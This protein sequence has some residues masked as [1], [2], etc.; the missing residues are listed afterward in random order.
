M[1][2]GYRELKW[3]CPLCSYES[4]V[5]EDAFCKLDFLIIDHSKTI[6]DGKLFRKLVFVWEEL[7]NDE[8]EELNLRI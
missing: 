4:V 6:L 7:R 3:T 5:G 8:I 2:E 1:S